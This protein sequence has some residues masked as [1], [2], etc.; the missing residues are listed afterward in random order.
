MRKR[1]WLVVAFVGVAAGCRVEPDAAW[2]PAGAG[3]SHGAAVEPGDGSP[4]GLDAM[5]GSAGA[6]RD[7][8]VTASSGGAGTNAGGGAP[9]GASARGGAS[10]AGGDPGAFEDA[11]AGGEGAVVYCDAQPVTFD[12][13]RRGEVRL[14]ARAAIDAVATSQKFLVSHASSGS[15][16]FGAYVGADAGDDGPRGFLL[17]SY[18]DEALDGDPCVPGSDGIPDEV[19]PGDRVT[20]AGRFSSYAPSSCSG[21]VAS[22][23]LL[24]EASCP[25]TLGGHGEPPS[26][27]PLSRAD[28]DHL[29]AGDDA[30]FVQ[31]WAGGLVRLT[32]VNGLPDDGGEDVVGPYGVIRFAETALP[33]T[34]DVG[35]GDLSLGGPGDPQ[36][37]LSF[38]YPT[39]FVS[40]TGIVH[41]DYCA[42]SLAPRERC[43]NIDPPST[44]CR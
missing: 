42:W 39:H 16:L 31:R 7:A 33:L 14:G 34:N 5:V 36:K 15:C 27:V 18:G 28:A 22:P 3:G 9:T 30:A 41:L 38:P 35:Y 44:G 8:G 6:G 12:E 23:Q 19:R 32:D 2:V 4:A 21:T 43:V 37:S 10:S 40:V 24:V 29:A 20:A 11:A 1:A 13:I 17:V 25:V 26:A